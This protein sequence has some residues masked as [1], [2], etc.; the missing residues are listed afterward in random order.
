MSNKNRNRRVEYLVG[1]KLV[2]LRVA[3]PHDWKECVRISII[4]GLTYAI[5]SAAIAFWM[6]VM[7]YKLVLVGVVGLSGFV[8]LLI[9]GVVYD[10]IGRAYVTGAGSK[11][12]VGRRILDGELH[13][14]SIK[15]GGRE[16]KRLGGLRSRESGR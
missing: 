5:C 1:E 12:K 3:L 10:L 16:C 9:S 6:P 11:A 7:V 14:E 8:L 15:L 2:P 13:R 4:A